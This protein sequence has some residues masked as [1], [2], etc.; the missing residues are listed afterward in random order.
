MAQAPSTITI[1]D[2]LAAPVARTFTCVKASP[3]LTKFLD[4]RLAKV[5][6]WPE[7][8]LQADVPST[9]A[10]TRTFELRV[11][12]PVVDAVTGLVVDTGMIRIV[13]DIPL[14]MAQAEVDDLYAFALNSAQH[15]VIK[16]AAK[17]LDVIVG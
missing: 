2:G 6:Y 15:A 1:N 12:K 9:K 8:T 13:G 16:A 5:A 10:R 3:E 11:R 4:K 17:D 7:L 14:S